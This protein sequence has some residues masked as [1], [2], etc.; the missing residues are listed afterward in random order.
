MHEDKVRVQP[1]FAVEPAH[2]FYSLRVEYPI[3]GKKTVET[4]ASM[5]AVVARAA[6]LIQ[7]GC[8]IGISST[9]A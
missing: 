5:R 7:A 6:E 3:S 9:A 2:D 4:Y 8:S 1:G